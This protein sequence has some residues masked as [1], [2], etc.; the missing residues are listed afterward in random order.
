MICLFFAA[1]TVSA[2]EVKG[3]FEADVI[4]HSLSEKDKAA[5]LK[6]ALSIVIK[7]IA[8]GDNLLGNSTVKAALNKAEFYV[9]QVQYALEPENRSKKTART[10]RVLFNEETLMAVIRNSKLAV[11]NEVR[12][13]VLVWLVVEK[14]GSKT[15]LNMKEDFEVYSRLQVVA[16]KKG[17]PLMLP[18]MDLED[19]RELA[20][21]DILS[22]Y[23]GKVLKASR[24]YGVSAILSG[25]VIHKRNCWY[26]EWTLHFDGKVQ[27]WS[28]PC[29]GLEQTLSVAMQGIYDQLSAF[30]AVKSE[31]REGGSVILNIKGIKGMTAEST[32]KAYLKK[33]PKVS[34]VKWLKV[35]KGFHV[36]KLNFSGKR[37]DLEKAIALQRLLLKQKSAGKSIN[38]QLV[39]Q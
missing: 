21:D 3:L 12:D 32:I 6:E 9:E 37:E 4:T 25:S 5:A 11:W 30:H 33:L 28:L 8:A 7:R 38:Y 2:V 17:V 26:S 31:N 23:S 27:Q 20:V 15:L 16:K 36:F 10:M 35:E 24:R 29:E 39:S 14:F 18:L 1:Q 22:A 34:A 19:K 13:E